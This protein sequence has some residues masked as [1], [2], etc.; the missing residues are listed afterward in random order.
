M[1]KRYCTMPKIPYFRKW[2]ESNF[3]DLCAI[4]DMEYQKITNRQEKK[5]ADFTFAMKIAERG[6]L[7]FALIALIAVSL[8][9]VRTDLK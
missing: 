6:H 7:F 1:G 5:V 2:F 8:P 4:H 3:G 9:W